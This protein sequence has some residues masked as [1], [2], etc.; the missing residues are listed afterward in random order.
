MANRRTSQGFS[1]IELMVGLAIGLFAMLAMSKILITFS[2]Q[3]TSV[4]Q[5]MAS[6]NNGVMALYLLERDLAQSGYAMMQLQNC[7]R[8]NYHFNGTGYYVSPYGTANLPG[9]AAQHIALTALPVRIIDGDTGSDTLEIQFGNPANGSPGTEVT[10]PGQVSWSDPFPV[11]SA[12]GFTNGDRF[13]ANIPNGAAS[14][15]C[16]MGAITN[17]NPVASPLEHAVANP[18][19]VAAAPGGTGWAPVT[20]VAYSSTSRPNTPYIANLGNFVSRRYTLSAAGVLP[21]LNVAEFPGFAA[22]T[23]VD[24]I[25]FLKAQYGLAATPCAGTLCTIVASW[26]DPGTF[27]IDNTNA[28]RVIAIRLAIV[29]R[30]PLLEREAPAGVSPTLSVLPTVAGTSTVSDPA[31]GECATDAATLEVKCTVANPNFRY[32]VVNT[33]VP[34]KN[35][36]WNR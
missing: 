26:A 7:D 2:Q 6:Q 25:V 15:T 33:T 14:G 31:A 17:A 36:I 16:T 32:R 27:V 34:L 11:T 29:A 13:V 5:T 12:L 1:L 3:R 28:A 22:S 10:A 24:D 19:N 4:T 18:Y 9:N 30:S 8:I 23:L 21:T 20:V 35:S